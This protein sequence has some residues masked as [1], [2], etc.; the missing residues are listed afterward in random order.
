VDF[1]HPG[2]AWATWRVGVLE[3]LASPAGLRDVEQQPGIRG[4]DVV[5]TSVASRPTKSALG[6][7]P[8]TAPAAALV[9]QR[10][11]SSEGN[12]DASPSPMR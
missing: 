5:E 12:S 8:L 9:T 6:E 4:V 3:H 7:R 10:A 2:T 11:P 1:E